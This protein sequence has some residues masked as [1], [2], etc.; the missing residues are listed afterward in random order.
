MGDEKLLTSSRIRFS[1]LGAFRCEMLHTDLDHAA[2]LIGGHKPPD[3]PHRSEPPVELE[4]NVRCRFM[5]QE[6]GF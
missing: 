3:I 1:I 4:H 2:G 6:M 5:L